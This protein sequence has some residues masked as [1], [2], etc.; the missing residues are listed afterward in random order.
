M[1]TPAVTQ[2]NPAIGPRYLAD[3]VQPSTG[4]EDKFCRRSNKHVQAM[5]DPG[6]NGTAG[7]DSEI[8]NLGA[9][10]WRT[11]RW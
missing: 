3:R 10:K 1:N 9:P 5:S 7:V 4:G 2:V 8:R 11:G 6:W